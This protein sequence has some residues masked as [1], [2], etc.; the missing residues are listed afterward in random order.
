MMFYMIDHT[1]DWH[2]FN[3]DTVSYV[4]KLVYL[5][6]VNILYHSPRCITSPRTVILEFRC[7]MFGADKLPVIIG[8]TSK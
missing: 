4:S 2:I 7:S 5:I 1:I 3:N 8:L 6:L